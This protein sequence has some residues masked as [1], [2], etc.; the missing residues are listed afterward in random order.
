[1]TPTEKTKISANESLS[2]SSVSAP[3][4]RPVDASTDAY[5][6]AP[7]RRFSTHVAWTLI[8]RLLILAGGL[9][10]GIIVARKLGAE[11]LGTLTVINVT[12]PLFL[13]LGCAGLPSA[14]TY[15]ISRDRRELAPVWANALL[16]GF[17]AGTVLAAAAACLAYLRPTLF[18]NVPLPLILTAAASIPFQLVTFLGLNVLLGIDRVGQ[19]NLMDALAQS[20]VLVN[21]VTALLVLGGGLPLLI[22]LNTAVSVV[23]CA[24]VML[25][26]GRAIAKDKGGRAFQVDAEL[27]RRMARYG[28]K[29][30]VAVVAS[31][32]IFRADLLIVNHFRGEAEAGGYAV[33]SQVAMLLMMLPGV[34]ATLIFPRVTATQ[35]VEGRLIMR[36]TRY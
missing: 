4:V 25:I 23:V 17:L 16:F 18:G 15:F 32:L 28:M 24:A 5:T 12:V 34:I 21:T 10:A 6:G 20:F 36:A 2:P 30:H 11:G 33:A 22:A 26:I 14:N 9:L 35:D 7:R 31:L 8:A 3:A 19:F 13:Q 29:F 1:M 27:L